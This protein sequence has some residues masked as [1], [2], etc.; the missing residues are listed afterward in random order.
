MWMISLQSIPIL[1]STFMVRIQAEKFKIEWW[2]NLKVMQLYHRQ[3]QYCSLWYFFFLVKTDGY[4]LQCTIILINISFSV[5]DTILRTLKL[6]R[7]EAICAVHKTKEN[8]P[9]CQQRKPGKKEGDGK[10]LPRMANSKTSLF[11]IR[12]CLFH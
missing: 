1:M 10:I 5:R 7:I 12:E 4:C 6:Q 2:L 11:L 3:Y 9:Y 8:H